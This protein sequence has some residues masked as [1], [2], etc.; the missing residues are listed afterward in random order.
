MTIGFMDFGENVSFRSETLAIFHLSDCFHHIW[1]F[2]CDSVHSF[3]DF[4]C[5][6]LLSVIKMERNQGYLLFQFFLRPHLYLLILSLVEVQGKQTK[7]MLKITLAM[8]H[9]LSSLQH[10]SFVSLVDSDIRIEA[11]RVVH[12]IHKVSFLI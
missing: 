1:S 5:T 2:L 4:N 9:L 12:F 11:P 10:F 6:F 3:G 8:V 7:K